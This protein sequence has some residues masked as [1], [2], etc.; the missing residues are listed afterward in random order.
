LK[1][2]IVDSPPDHDFYDQFDVHGSDDILAYD[3]TLTIEEV[4]EFAYN[5]FY[6]SWGI[7]LYIYWKI[8]MCY[9]TIPKE[10]RKAFSTVHWLLFLIDL[11]TKIS[12]YFFYKSVT[13]SPIG[14]TLNVLCFI[15]TVKHPAR[16]LYKLLQWRY[17]SDLEP[18]EQLIILPHFSS[19]RIWES[20]TSSRRIRLVAF[21]RKV[22]PKAI[23]QF[24]PMY[25]VLNNP[26]FRSLYEA[27]IGSSFFLAVFGDS[28]SRRFYLRKQNLTITVC[29][30]VPLEGGDYRATSYQVTE[31][32]DPNPYLYK[33]KVFCGNQD[34][35]DSYDMVVSFAMVKEFL[36]LPKC[37]SPTES[38]ET[39]ESKI[40]HNLGGM[41]YINI[42]AG[43]NTQLNIINNTF[44]YLRYKI[45]SNRQN[46]LHRLPPSGGFPCPTY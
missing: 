17:F 11:L 9:N 31:L 42:P 35:T 15:I 44:H 20:F 28:H 3:P 23:P 7:L 24:K 19:W 27:P 43:F 6:M 30:P 10:Y 25:F 16:W 37:V 18:E 29:D 12:E 33:V 21:E 13:F 41:N 14:L 34:S 22:G 26:K 2:V 32:K 8:K 1:E 46:D 45:I 40:V 5:R 39:I 36:A 4:R 38:I